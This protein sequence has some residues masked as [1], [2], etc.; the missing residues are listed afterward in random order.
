MA[1]EIREKKLA[2]VPLKGDKI[3]LDVSIAYLKDQQ[4]SPPA[5]AFLRILEKL[6]P[7]SDMSPQGIGS[8]MAKVLA[9]KIQAG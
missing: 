5:R 4:L 8:L 1:A 2:A 6:Q 9:G 7:K 3:F